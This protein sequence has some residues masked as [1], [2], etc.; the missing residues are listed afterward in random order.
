MTVSNL[1]YN[2]PILNI[3]ADDFKVSFEEAS[4][5]PTLMQAGYAAGLLFICPLGDVVRR[6]PFTVALVFLSAAVWIGL[7]TTTSFQVFLSLS[8]IV[9]LTTVTPQIM[10]PLVGELA[11]PRRRGAMIGTVFSGL[12]TGVLIARILSGVVT[13][14]T[15]WRTIYF[16]G[17]GLQYALFT[18][19]FLFLPDYPSMNPD[20]VSYGRILWTIITIPTRQPVLVQMSVISFLTSAVFISFWTTLTFLLASPPFSLSPVPIGLFALIGI[21][22]FFLNPFVSHHLTNRFH[23]IYA[24]IGALVIDLIGVVISTAIGTF[25][26]AGPVIQAFVVDVGLI[27]GQTA[28]RTQ[29]VPVEPKARN[30]VNTVFMATSFCGMLTGT[31]VGNRLY[32]EGG[33]RYSNGASIVFLVLALGMCVIRGPYETRWFGWS[34]GWS[35]RS[36]VVSLD[37]AVTVAREDVDQAMSGETKAEKGFRKYS[38]ADF[39]KTVFTGRSNKT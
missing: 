26:L 38:V 18:L 13:Q 23:P 14:F 25:S 29:L 4:R 11:P 24:C 33:W 17:L 39:Q 16:T 10:L 27:I 28:N 9:G 34:G 2:H 31:A 36:D 1:Y 37:G 32:A 21:P 19:L 8:F 6:R 22:P 5:I 30:R 15:G 7:C 3:L 12:F 20:G 35:Q